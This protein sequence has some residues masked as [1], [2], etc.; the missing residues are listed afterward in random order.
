L[1]TAQIQNTMNTLEIETNLHCLGAEKISFF[2]ATAEH[3][4]VEFEDLDL[5][6]G[7]DYVKIKSVP[8]SRHQE[9]KMANIGK[10]HWRLSD[11]VIVCLG[12]GIDLPPNYFTQLLD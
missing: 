6:L 10:V 2:I 12:S 3:N 7:L 4:G 9:I 8:Y 11:F 5:G 1:S